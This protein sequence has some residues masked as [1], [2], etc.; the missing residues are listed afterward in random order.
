MKNN[1]KKGVVDGNGNI[2]LGIS[3]DNMFIKVKIEPVKMDDGTY[4]I[5]VWV[6]DD[7][8]GIGTLTYISSD[9]SFGALGHGISD[10]D[11]GKLLASNNGA[12]YKAKIWG[13]TKGEVGKPGG[14]LVKSQ[15]IQQKEYLV[16]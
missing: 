8:Q 6:R 15:I 16:L 4:K 13:I 5:G 2:I 12:L 3:R 1:G 14:Y 9:G 7:T 11:T 10:V